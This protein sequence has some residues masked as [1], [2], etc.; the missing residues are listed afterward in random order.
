[1]GQ[2]LFLFQLNSENLNSLCFPNFLLSSLSVF[3]F[4]VPTLIT[5]EL[6]LCAW[7]PG[8]LVL[9]TVSPDFIKNFKLVPF[10]LFSVSHSEK[11][12][13]LPF[14]GEMRDRTLY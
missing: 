13:R 7:D 10:H 3:N 9:M 5:N 11:L 4:T 2:L 8:I 1:M 14:G 12:I 6:D